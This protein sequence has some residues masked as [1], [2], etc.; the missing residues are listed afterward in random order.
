MKLWQ[1]KETLI[2]VESPKSYLYMMARNRGLNLLAKI[3]RDKKLAEQ[4]W[5]NIAK[6]ENYTN[7]P[8]EAKETVLLI[9]EAVTKLPEK[10][11]QIFLFENSF[12]L[13]DFFVSDG[14]F[15]RSDL[16]FI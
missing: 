15:P 2:H 14:A 4:A 9:N 7:D 8:L 12:R 6:F 1:T 16:W 3:A 11:Q 13:N 5:A 10:K